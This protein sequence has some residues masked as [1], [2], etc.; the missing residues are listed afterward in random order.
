VPT[1]VLEAIKLGLWNYDPETTTGGE[2]DSTEAMPGTQ[3]KI[4]VLAKR[5]E[6]GLPLW[7]PRDRRTYKDN[8]QDR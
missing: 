7:H 1:S 2:Y 5:L 4:A 3:E 8:D 6:R